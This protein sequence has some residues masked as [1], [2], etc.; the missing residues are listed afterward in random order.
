[1]YNVKM[2][3]Y[4]QEQHPTAPVIR[5][6]YIR[7]PTRGMGFADFRWI[8][9]TKARHFTRHDEKNLQPGVKKHNLP[10]TVVV[11]TTR[12]IRFLKITS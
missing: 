4:T 6:Y 1:M 5:M 7:A 3:I 8:Y 9:Y 12:I 10:Q 2:H 11:S